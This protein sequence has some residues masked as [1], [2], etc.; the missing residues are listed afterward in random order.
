MEKAN[1]LISLKCRAYCS[2]PTCGM[3]G[4]SMHRFPKSA[5]LRF[6]WK[7]LCHI[8]RNISNTMFVCRRHSRSEDNYETSKSKSRIY[9]RS[10]NS[11]SKELIRFCVQSQFAGS[12][13]VRLFRGALPCL[14]LPAF[15][16]VNRMERISSKQRR[17]HKC[18]IKSCS[19]DEASLHNFPRSSTRREEWRRLCRIN[20]PVSRNTLICGKHFVPSD[21][22]NIGSPSFAT[23]FSFTV[24]VA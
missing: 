4:G 21:F 14:K 2:V 1:S 23:Q 15:T 24:T 6:L 5:P 12:G 17:R 22:K 9:T 16:S 7:S 19:S 8:Q 18:S 10:V 3:R 13:L 20:A 11:L